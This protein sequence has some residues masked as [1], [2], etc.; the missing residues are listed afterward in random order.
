MGLNIRYGGDVDSAQ[1]KRE[2]ARFTGRKW[3]ALHQDA[4]QAGRGVAS[5]AKPRRAA[6]LAGVGREGRLADA[7]S[8]MVKARYHGSTGLR[9]VLPASCANGVNLLGHEEQAHRDSVALPANVATAG[10]A[11]PRSQYETA[12]TEVSRVAGPDEE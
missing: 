9:H 8:F 12:Y 2:V 6:A 3:G 7:P 1:R 4:V 10:R 11:R 5:A